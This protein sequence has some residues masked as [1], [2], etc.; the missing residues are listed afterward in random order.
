[1]N[2]FD[3]TFD[4]ISLEATLIKEGNDSDHLAGGMINEEKM[5]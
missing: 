1:M 3:I 5:S 4:K 2:L